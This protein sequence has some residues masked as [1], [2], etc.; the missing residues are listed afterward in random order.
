MPDVRIEE[1]DVA[2]NPAVAMKYRVMATPALAI[3]GRLAF[4][5][6]PSARSLRARLE[7]AAREAPGA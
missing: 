1:I 3:N 5:G 4:T 7:A 2:E 6:V